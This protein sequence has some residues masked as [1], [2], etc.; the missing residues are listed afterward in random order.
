MDVVVWGVWKLLNRHLIRD[1]A[2]FG[3]TAANKHL[4]ELEVE[5]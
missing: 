5:R 4:L 3:N 2:L 1:Q